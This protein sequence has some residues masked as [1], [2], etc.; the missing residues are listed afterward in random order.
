MEINK[1]SKIQ[2]PV[3][4]NSIEKDFEYLDFNSLDSVGGLTKEYSYSCGDEQFI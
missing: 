2:T 1:F 4:M 3:T